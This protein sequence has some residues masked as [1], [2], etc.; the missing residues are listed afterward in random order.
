MLCAMFAPVLKWWIF[1]FPL[2]TILFII[3]RRVS[4]RQKVLIFKLLFR[5][6]AGKNETRQDGR[7]FNNKQFIFLFFEFKVFLAGMTSQR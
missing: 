4:C 1:K 3:Y 2:L 7:T 5:Y 6:F